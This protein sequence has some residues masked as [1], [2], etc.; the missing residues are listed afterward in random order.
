[1]NDSPAHSAA[2]VADIDGYYDKFYVHDADEIRHHLQRLVGEHCVLTVHAEGS[3]DSMATML[4]RVDASGFWIDV[5][6]NRALLDAWMAATTLRFEGSLDRAALRFP[7]GPARLGVHGDRPALQ[8]PIPTRVLYLQRREFMRR[9]PPA[10]TLACH[11]HLLDGQEVD[12]TIRDIGGGGLAVVAIRSAVGFHV[13]D[14]LAG[15]RIELPDIGEVEV[16]LQIRHILTRGH[17]GHDAMQAGCEFVNL[18]P[19]VQQGVGQ[20]RVQLDRD[21]LTRRRRDE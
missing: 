10:G 2:D 6:N 12:A 16:D 8:V 14:V 9:E 11:L 7:S 15:C 5:P 3:N 1:M 18:S 4:L 20:P 19:A 13:G 17:I 21:Q